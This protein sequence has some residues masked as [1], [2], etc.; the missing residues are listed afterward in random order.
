MLRPHIECYLF[1]VVPR[2]PSR[3]PLLE[4]GLEMAAVHRKSLMESISFAV[5]EVC[6]KYIHKDISIVSVEGMLGLQF[7]DDHALLF[8]INEA[9]THTLN[10]EVKS[11][12]LAE[13]R[14]GSADGNDPTRTDSC[15]TEDNFTPGHANSSFQRDDENLN[16]PVRVKQEVMDDTESGLS[17]DINVMKASDDA[18]LQDMFLYSPS[19]YPMHSG[20]NNFDGEVAEEGS[21]SPLAHHGLA[22]Y[23][24]TLY[25][26]ASIE[27]N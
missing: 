2:L 4:P 25:D 16:I 22:A 7:E 13:T 1:I 21:S 15:D 8:S 6:R 27:V 17:T 20:D 3:Y 26:D 14:T 11:S 10:E 24:N 5:S 18:G 9:R 23:Q 12:L 19:T